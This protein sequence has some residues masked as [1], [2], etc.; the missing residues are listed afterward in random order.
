MA[1]VA[2]RIAF[3]LITAIVGGVIATKAGTADRTVLGVLA[4]LAAGP[5]RRR[6]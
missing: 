4:G 2:L 5:R 6:R 1:L 3:V